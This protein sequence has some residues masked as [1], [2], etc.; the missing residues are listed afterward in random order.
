M[1]AVERQDY[2][3]KVQELLGDQDTYRPISED[4]PQA[5]KST[6]TNGQNCKSQ[7]QVSQATYKRLYPMCA[8]PAKFCGLPKIHKQGTPLDP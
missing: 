2:V 6:Y 3:Y 8:I 7:G 4:P 5:Q 1:V